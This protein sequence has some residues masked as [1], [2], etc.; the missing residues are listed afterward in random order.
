MPASSPRLAYHQDT[1]VLREHRGH[2]LGLV[3]KLANVP[4]LR[5]AFPEVRTVRTWNAVENAHMLAVN[6]AM[7]YVTSGFLREWQKRR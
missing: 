1:L 6:D 7:G 3:L 4:V 5:R 2:G